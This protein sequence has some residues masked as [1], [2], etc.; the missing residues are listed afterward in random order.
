VHTGGGKGK[1]TASLN[2]NIMAKKNLVLV[3]TGKNSLHTTWAT[4]GQ[5]RDFD[6]FALDYEPVNHGQIGSI[7]QVFEL[8]GPKIGGYFK[9]LSQNKDTIVEYARVA[10]LDDDL[11]TSYTDISRV[12]KYCDLLDLDI[13]QPALTHNSFYSVPITRKHRS[14]LHRWTNWVEIM[15]PF[16]KSDVLLSCIDSFQSN[17]NGGSCIEYLWTA[18]CKSIPGSIAIIDHIPFFHTRPVGSAGSAIKGNKNPFLPLYEGRIIEMLNGA[19]P[20]ADNICGLTTEGI[21]MHAGEQ[22]FAQ[23]VLEDFTAYG[24]QNHVRI[25]YSGGAKKTSEVCNSYARNVT[26]NFESLQF[27]R[28]LSEDL[29]NTFACLAIQSGLLFE[30]L[31]AV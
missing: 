5:E 13:G 8:H 19:G 11:S 21:F 16:F 14:F 12:F 9:W 3:R 18:H 10:L 1:F 24:V 6:I 22:M 7:D 20:S 27:I 30:Q 15:A 29:K 17:Q 31:K 25:A 28:F 26:L 4:A 23:L 2:K